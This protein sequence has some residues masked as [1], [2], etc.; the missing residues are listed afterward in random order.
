[1]AISVTSMN[2]FPCFKITATR[3]W[4]SNTRLNTMLTFI[5]AHY[6]S[7]SCAYI[8]HRKE[9]NENTGYLN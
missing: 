8:L 2:N 9:C 1:M 6:L 4:L 5:E 7:Y 3:S